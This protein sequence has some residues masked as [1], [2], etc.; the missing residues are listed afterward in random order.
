MLAHLIPLAAV[1]C[2]AA[3]AARAACAVQLDGDPE[4]IAPVRRA[5]EGFGD[6]DATCVDV[7]ALC[8][9]DAA[10]I[11]IDLRDELG[12]SVQRRFTTPEGAA[13]FLISWSRRPLPQTG[14]GL[15]PVAPPMAA[16]PGAARPDLL[17]RGAAAG[18][19]PRST[20][21]PGL[22]PPGASPARPPSPDAPP[23]GARTAAAA[24]VPGLTIGASVPPTGETAERA[25]GPARDDR[26][27]HPEIRAAYIS[28]P[29]GLP[30]VDGVAGMVETALLARHDSLR[31]GLVARALGASVTQQH[32]VEPMSHLSWLEADAEL[33]IGTRWRFDR[34]TLGG[35]LFGG[36]GLLTV[37]SRSADPAVEARTPGA[38][39]GARIVVAS[40]LVSSVWFDARL[41]WDGLRQL[42]LSGQS[43][44]VLRSDRY[45]GQV[46]LEIGVLWAP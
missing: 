7:R 12:R 8:S 32:F 20:A 27:I 2:G 23:A 3:S 31:A 9:R 38:R 18:D 11:V 21:P 19:P 40:Q 35:E 43:D 33:T 29:F 28:A 22:T 25:T 26:G 36:A 37:L 5:I 14:T 42:G 1:L 6:D 13:A 4:V 44:E 41:G 17:P 46:H 15:E 10:D 24:G 45:L 39:G 30:T 16:P 34:V